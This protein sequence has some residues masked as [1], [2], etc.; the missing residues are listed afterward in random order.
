M[1]TGR[2]LYREASIQEHRTAMLEKTAEF[3]RLSNVAY[4]EYQAELAKF[5]PEQR[6]FT[7]RCGACHAVDTVRV[8]PPL[9]EIA[10]IYRDRPEGIVAWA[11]APGKKRAGFPQMPSMKHVGEKDLLTIAEYMLATG[12]SVPL[13]VPSAT[14]TK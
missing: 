10:T 5:P 11:L 9:R 3:E 2:H 12:T 7:A 6:L 13:P 14:A 1:G 8:G 4:L